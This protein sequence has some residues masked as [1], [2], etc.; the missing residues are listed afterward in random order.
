MGI[1]EARELSSDQIRSICKSNADDE[2]DDG[3][4]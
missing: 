4:G 3:K 2:Y 1:D